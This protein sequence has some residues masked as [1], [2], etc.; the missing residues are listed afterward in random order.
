MHWGRVLFAK[1]WSSSITLVS[2]EKLNM[3][4]STEMPFFLMPFCGEAMQKRH[5]RAQV[6]VSFVYNPE[7]P[8]GLELMVE[9]ERQV[10][11]LIER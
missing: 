10:H 9:R 4:K 3:E 8:F 7:A 1:R 11:L 5:P 6:K 2:P